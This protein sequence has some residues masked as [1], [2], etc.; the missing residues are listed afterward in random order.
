MSQGNVEIVRR[1]FEH[2]TTTGEVSRENMD[3][4]FVWDMSTA[5]APE[6]DRDAG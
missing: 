3:P 4:E 2:Y 6:G 5:R 1:G